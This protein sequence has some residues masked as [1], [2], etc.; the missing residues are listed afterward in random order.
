MR[1]F[2]CA[3][4][5]LAGRAAGLLPPARVPYGQ[6]QIGQWLGGH[7]RRIAMLPYPIVILRYSLCWLFDVFSWSITID[8]AHKTMNSSVQQHAAT[9]AAAPIRCIASTTLPSATLPPVAGVAR[10]RGHPRSTPRTCATAAPTTMTTEWFQYIVPLK[11]R[12]R[13]CHVVTRELVGVLDALSDIEC[14][15]A[16]FFIQ[17]TSASLTINENASPDVPLDLNV[18]GARLYT[19]LQAF[20]NGVTGR[21]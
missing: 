7:Y 13:G 18:C 6:T 11:A 14:G 19:I 9:F 1:A 17:H 5:M 4:D 15:L 2:V 8:L 12:P 16:T 3:G 10:H 20:S 21:A